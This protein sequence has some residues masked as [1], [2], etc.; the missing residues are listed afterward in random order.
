[1]AQR[2]RRLTT[3]QKIPGS[4]PGRVDFFSCFFYLVHGRMFSL[5]IARSGD[6]SFHCSHSKVIVILKTE[7]C[8]VTHCNHVA[9]SSVLYL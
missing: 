7:K 4:N 9:Y 5:E 3:D 1:M 8:A 2:I 6:D